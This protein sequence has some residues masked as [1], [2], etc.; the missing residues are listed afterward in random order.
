MKETLNL[1]LSHVRRERS[2]GLRVGGWEKGRRRLRRP[3]YPLSLGGDPL[4]LKPGGI[5]MRSS[6]MTKYA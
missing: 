5:W 4:R 3:P 6:A 2:H 1:A